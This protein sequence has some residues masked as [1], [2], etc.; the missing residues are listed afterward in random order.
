M[1]KL[2]ALIV[3]AILVSCSSA[4]NEEKAGRPDSP[5]KVEDLAG[6]RLKAEAMYPV[7]PL[8]KGAPA[9]PTTGGC[10]TELCEVDRASFG[11]KDW[12]KAWQ[13]D[14]QAQRN[15]A[16]CRSTGCGGAVETNAA[17]ACAWRSIILA[18]HVGTANDTDAANLRMDCGKL[19]DAGVAV[20]I[21]NAQS[22]YPRIYD[23]SMPAEATVKR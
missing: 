17:E 19:D 22:I 18:A 16:Y 21:N 7:H 15:V 13:G 8:P 11:R 9:A 1:K 23:K 3:A 4:E 14:Y 12:P 10:V 2:V 6:A 5:K 20:A